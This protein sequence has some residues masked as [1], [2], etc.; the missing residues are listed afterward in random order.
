MGTIEWILIEQYDG[1][2]NVLE[3][4]SWKQCKRSIIGWEDKAKEMN[5]GPESKPG[6]LDLGG[7][8]FSP[9]LRELTWWS[10]GKRNCESRVWSL[11]DHE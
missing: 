4:F 6:M 11:G 5:K 10:R 8:A 9:Y 2:M 3:A 7:G 1:Q